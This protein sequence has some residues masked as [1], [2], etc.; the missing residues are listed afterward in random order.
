MHLASVNKQF[1]ISVYICAYLVGYTYDYVEVV[2]SKVQQ[3]INI[4]RI[5]PND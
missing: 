1:M 2:C 5:D 3:V 4:V